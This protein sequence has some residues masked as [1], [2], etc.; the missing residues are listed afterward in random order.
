MQPNHSSHFTVGSLEPRGVRHRQPIARRHHLS[1]PRDTPKA[2]TA[3]CSLPPPAEL[4][5]DVMVLIDGGSM[6]G[7]ASVEKTRCASPE[8]TAVLTENAT[9]VGAHLL[10]VTDMA[11]VDTKAGAC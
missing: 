3:V 11:G 9:I 1:P 10:P 4:R 5:A 7:N 2:P 8:P 6:R